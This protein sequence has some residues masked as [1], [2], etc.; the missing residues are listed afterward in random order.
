MR[1]RIILKTYFDPGIY[2]GPMG[3]L[4]VDPVTFTKRG[5]NTTCIKSG[6]PPIVHIG[7]NIYF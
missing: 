7:I 3:H 6:V 5:V 2:D 4:P 1:F